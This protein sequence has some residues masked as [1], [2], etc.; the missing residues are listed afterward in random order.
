MEHSPSQA[1]RFSVR[2]FPTFLGTRGFITAFTT[3]RYLSLSWASSIQSMPSHPTS[4][5]SI[6]ISYHLHL[7][8]PSGLFPSAFPTKSLYSPL[9][10]PIHATCP[11]QFIFLDLIRRITFG[12]QYRS[13]SS[14][15]CSFLHSPVTSSVLV[16]P[17]RC[18]FTARYGLSL[19]VVQTS[20]H[21]MYRQV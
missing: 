13:L 18:V 14:S 10:Y 9:F 6:L 17:R 3:A 15:L 11:A 12:E 4:W 21:Y 19:W 7:G 2:K 8:L 5:R 16:P 1:N 20:G